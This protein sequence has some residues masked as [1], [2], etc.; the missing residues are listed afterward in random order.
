MWEKYSF[1]RSAHQTQLNALE[2]KVSVSPLLLVIDPNFSQESIV[3]MDYL[4]ELNA[5]PP[6]KFVRYV[7]RP[8]PVPAREFNFT[9]EEHLPLEVG[10]FLA[11]PVEVLEENLPSHYVYYKDEGSITNIPIAYV[12]EILA[13]A[14]IWESEREIGKQLSRASLVAYLSAEGLGFDLFVS[15]SDYLIA[16]YQ[17]GKTYAVSPADALAF[18]GLTMRMRGETILGVSDTGH[19]TATNDWAYFLESRYLFEPIARLAIRDDTQSSYFNLLSGAVQRGQQLLRLRDELV[20]F[21]LGDKDT[22]L[23]DPIFTFESFWI[24]A[25]GIFDCI[26]QALNVAFSMGV[27]TRL[28]KFR[29]GTFKNKIPT[30]LPKVQEFIDAHGTYSLVDIVSE[31]RNTIHQEP[32]S[33]TT[34]LHNQNDY[35]VMVS[36]EVSRLLIDNSDRFGL[37]AGIAGQDTDGRLH[38]KPIAFLEILL[39]QIVFHLNGLVQVPRWP[40]H[41]D[42]PPAFSANAV[43][44][45]FIR[46]AK[47]NHAL[48]GID[49]TTTRGS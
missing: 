14:R 33:L 29:N 2:V 27:N 21:Q 13:R 32:S 39:P 5:S 36:P 43:D 23:T 35:Y 12:D 7:D 24:Y 18:G 20:V 34:I 47:R 9:N 26:S 15:D 10:E 44:G 48:F 37:R 31:L 11:V 8:I 41:F 42:P 3:E 40:R 45:L 49:R 25:S 46:S 17:L 28:A 22:Y 16:N 38:L 6:F 1:Q 4:R 30:L 19:H